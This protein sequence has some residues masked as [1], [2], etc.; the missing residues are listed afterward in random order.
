[1]WYRKRK[2]NATVYIH[3]DIG[4]AVVVN[5]NGISFEGVKYPTVKA[6]QA[7][8][9]GRLP[10]GTYKGVKVVKMTFNPDFTINYDLDLTEAER[11]V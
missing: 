2:G 10:P 3:P 7:V 9:M 11:V 1:M 8:A 5:H 4:R 6:A